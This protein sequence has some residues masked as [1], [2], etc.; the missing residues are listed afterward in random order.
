MDTTKVGF[1]LSA[2][3]GLTFNIDTLNNLYQCYRNFKN[4][5]FLIYDISKAN[6]GMNPL[7][8]YRLSEKAIETLERNT[9]PAI[10]KMNLVQDKIRSQN[11]TIQEL[12]EEVPIRI[13]RSHLLQAFLFD[14]IQPHM[15]AFN[16]NLF[17]LATPQYLCNHVYQLNEATEEL[18]FEQ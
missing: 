7:H 15:P 11:L 2:H 16:T 8:C 18:V 10:D 6:F 1:Y 17:K 5:I 9:N 14:H 12:F 4:S 3:M 13:H